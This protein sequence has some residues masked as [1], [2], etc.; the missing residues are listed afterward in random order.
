[1]NEIITPKQQS[2]QSQQ[3]QP[4]LAISIQPPP[5]QVDTTKLIRHLFAKLSDLEKRIQTL[6]QT[7]QN[8]TPH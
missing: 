8:R 3:S 6:E 4:P 5:L 7:Q 1:M 2:Q